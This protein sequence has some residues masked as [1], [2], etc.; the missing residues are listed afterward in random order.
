MAFGIIGQIRV[1]KGIEWLVPAF[2]NNAALG[3]LTVAGEFYM[4]QNREQLS[5]LS[6][7]DS[8]INRFMSESD[9]LEWAAEQD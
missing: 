9:M 4:S 3:K 2:Q 6:G 1:C 7:Y 8:F 5:V